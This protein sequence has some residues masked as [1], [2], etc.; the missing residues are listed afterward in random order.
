MPLQ[1][2]WSYVVAVGI[3]LALTP[4]LSPR[5]GRIFGSLERGSQFGELVIVEQVRRQ[6]AASRRGGSDG[7][8]QRECG[9]P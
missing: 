1:L 9:A 8:L 4:A 7:S 6:H 5:R 3:K 2:G